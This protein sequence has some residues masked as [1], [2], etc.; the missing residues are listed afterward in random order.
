[1]K[2][3]MERKVSA[4]VLALLG[5]VLIAASLVWFVHDLMGVSNWALREGAVVGAVLI[6]IV[7][8]VGELTRR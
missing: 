5:A 1:M 3:A 7:C 6:G 4:L 2:R 8:A